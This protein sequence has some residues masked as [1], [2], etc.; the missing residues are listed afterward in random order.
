[1]NFQGRKPSFNI[2]CLRRQGSGDDLPIPGTYHPT[3]PPRHVQ[4]TLSPHT[5]R[6]GDTLTQPSIVQVTSPCLLHPQQA[7]DSHHF[8]GRPSVTASVSWA[9]PCP[10]RGRLLYAPLILM[11][12]G[13]SPPWEA[14]GRVGEGKRGATGCSE[15]T[16]FSNEKMTYSEG[17]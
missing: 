4:V 3:S 11:E 7:Y 2:Q 13:C 10:R 5:C 6:P 16:D 9:K 8:L 14:G 1:M 12:E 17:F 15:E